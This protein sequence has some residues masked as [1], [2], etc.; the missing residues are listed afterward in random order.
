MERKIIHV[1]LITPGFPE[2]EKDT[3]CIPGMQD[4]LIQMRLDYP[5]IH[6]HVL[7]IHYPFNNIEYSWNTIPVISIGGK[8]SAYPIR[9]WY[10]VRV[11]NKA[12]Q[13]IRKNKIEII[14]AL[15]LGESSFLAGML[16]KKFRIPNVIS[17]MGQDGNAKKSVWDIFFDYQATLV[18]PS[19]RITMNAVRRFSG[20]R[21]YE[22]VLGIPDLKEKISPTKTWNFLGAGNLTTFK[23]YEI[24]ISVFSKLHS[25]NPEL[26]AILLGDGPQREKL[27][28][29][30]KANKVGDSFQFGGKVN[31]E[32]VL[33]YMSKSDIF[34]HPS[35]TEGFGI[36]F[37]EAL[38]SGMKIISGPVGIAEEGE[39]WKICESESDY[40]SAA[41]YFLSQP[42]LTTG[43]N[44]YPASETA[45]KYSAL[46]SE[47]ISGK[48][49]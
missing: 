40:F 28:S 25:E 46:Y 8:N 38:S 37:A 16:S 22:I 1:L 26:K 3:S 42:P 5:E 17:L 29:L 45:R 44:R 2:N 30:C 20:R 39:T 48:S 41:Q 6:F 10:W 9:F 15:W 21:V 34:F 32:T 43:L 13:I 7:S 19:N 31:R 24:F 47:I 49:R 4:W 27:E 11:W 14:H 12:K 33:D 18:S 23:N 35:Q 36:V